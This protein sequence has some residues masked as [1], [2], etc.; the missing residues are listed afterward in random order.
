MRHFRCTGK[1]RPG[2]LYVSRFLLAASIIPLL[3]A[4]V[5]S[6]GCSRNGEE[7]RLQKE[8]EWA[9]YNLTEGE[10]PP[11]KPKAL[12]EDL[13]IEVPASVKDKYAG[14]VMAVG[15]R[16][17]REVKKFNVMLGQSAQVP[18]TDYSVEVG[19][20]I[21]TWIMRGN[22][23]TSRKDEPDDPAVR[24]AIYKAGEKVF[25]GFIFQRHKTPSF[26]TDEHV[27]GLVGAVE[28]K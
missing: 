9:L 25:D 27:I 28:A 16:K 11:P 24:A 8:R 15:N 21:P 12:P 10:T 7:A 6:G 3:A 2:L 23:V 18:G 22:V 14:V 13:V 1:L 26:I 4:L 19:E 5:F 17:T 20:Y